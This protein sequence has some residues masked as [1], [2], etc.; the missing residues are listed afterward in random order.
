MRTG[1]LLE[2]HADE[3]RKSGLVLKH[4]LYLC[5]IHI[6]GLQDVLLIDR[7]IIPS[8]TPFFGVPSGVRA[9]RK[10]IPNPHIFQ[11]CLVIMRETP[12][13]EAGAFQ[14]NTGEMIMM[15]SVLLLSA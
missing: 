13:S 8:P 14:P 7:S 15:A 11:A 9:G 10:D 4:I 3:A 2:F 6:E 1:S 12:F 5:I